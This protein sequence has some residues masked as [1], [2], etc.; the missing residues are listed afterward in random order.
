M[1]VVK[2]V[3]RSGWTAVSCLAGA[4]LLGACSSSATSSS[5]GTSPG[6]S[7]PSASTTTTSGP[8]L[9]IGVSMSL[10]GDF[11]DLAG[12]ALKGYQLWAATVNANGGLLGRKVSLKVGDDASTPTQ[13]VCN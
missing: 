11:A 4:L 6:S 13:A 2:T 3:R 7:S 1:Q 9:V 8:P 12:P 10:S 5:S